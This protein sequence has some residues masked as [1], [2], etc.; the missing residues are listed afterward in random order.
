MITVRC[1]A[2]VREILGCETRTLP[3]SS[4]PQ[5]ASDILRIVAGARTTDLPKPLLVAINCE[6]ASLTSPVKDGDEIA[7]FPPVSGG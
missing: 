5:L 4:T 7:F 2:T 1:F 3:P 6:H